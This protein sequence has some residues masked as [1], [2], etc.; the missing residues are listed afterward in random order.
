MRS[1]S[2]VNIEL[3]ITGG[4]TGKAGTQVIRVQPDQLSPALAASLNECLKEVPDDAWGRTFMSAHPQSWDFMYC[5]RVTQ[6]GKEKS[7][8]F[9]KNE[10]PAQLT[11]ASEILIE[12]NAAT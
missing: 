3:E 9:Q 4:F 5:L 1:K 11:R 6:D 10:G 8:R 12:F 7:V 2:N